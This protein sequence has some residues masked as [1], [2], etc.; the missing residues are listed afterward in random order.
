MESLYRPKYRNAAGELVEWEEALRERRAYSDAVQ[1]ARGVIIPHVFHVKGRPIR[2]WRRRW[3]Q[4]LLKVGLA[5]REVDENGQPK[6]SSKIIPSVIVHDFRRGA[7]RA[8]SRAGVSEAVAM[9]LCGHETPSVYRRYRI[10]TGDDLREA[11]A[12][13]NTATASTG[14]VSGKVAAVASG[15]SA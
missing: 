8:L 1:H 11:A 14:K 7:I 10:V 13:L 15:A 2:Y 3:L 9:Q 6:K 5:Q 12:K 4:A